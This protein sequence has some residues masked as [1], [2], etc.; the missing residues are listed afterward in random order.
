M[1]NPVEFVAPEDDPDRTQL[2]A[3][4][5][6]R[7]PLPKRSVPWTPDIPAEVKGVRQGRHRKSQGTGRRKQPLWR[8]ILVLF[9][10]AIVLTIL[11]QAFLGRVYS[12]PSGSMEQTLHGC[13][14]CTGDRVLV[15]KIVYRFRD[16]RP[17][18]VIV[19]KGP[20]PWTK[21]DVD[22]QRSSNVL[23]RGLQQLGALVGL[24]PPDERDFVKR[25]IAVGGQ[26]VECCDPDNRVLVDGKPLDEPYIY[27]E[28]G[29]PNTQ[30]QFP[31]V[32]VPQGTLWVMG[33]NRN[34]SCDSRCQGGGK[35]TNGGLNGVV[36]VDNVI[37]KARYIVLPPSRWRGVGDHDPQQQPAQALGAAAWQRGMPA[38]VG[39]IGALPVL[40]LGRRLRRRRPGSLQ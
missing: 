19:F 12:I 13:T 26:S 7:Q 36:P 28:N 33:D 17:G 15:D 3:R 25:V 32:T 8:E 20:E 37:G 11:I 16:P 6:P 18:D 14:G 38:G 4:V 9:S 23:V 1:V 40:W 39:L 29:R 21:N 5:D 10:I 31:K 2:I 35:D 22:L 34:N 27:W 30:S 24:A